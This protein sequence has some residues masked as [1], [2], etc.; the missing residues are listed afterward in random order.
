MHVQ[1]CHFHFDYR[2]SYGS[3]ATCSLGSLHSPT[4]TSLLNGWCVGNVP[5]CPSSVLLNLIPFDCLGRSVS[6]SIRTLIMYIRRC[7][8]KE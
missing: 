6:Y 8:I 2:T 3:D 1:K 4:P 5:P 7:V